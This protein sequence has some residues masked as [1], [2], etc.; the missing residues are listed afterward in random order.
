MVSLTSSGFFESHETS[1][2][3]LNDFFNEIIIVLTLYTMMCFTNFLP[4]QMMQFNVGYASCF[5]VVTHLIINLSI[6]VM[7]STRQV[8]LKLK[9]F[10]YQRKLKTKKQLGVAPTQSTQVII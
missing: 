3:Q 2:A 5:L 10:F 4:D 9:R 8:V 7:G 6:M 1:G